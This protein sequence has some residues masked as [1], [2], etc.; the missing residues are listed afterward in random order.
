MIS[1]T[2]C[3]RDAMQG[4]K[5]Q[6]P[7]ELKAEYLNLLLKVGFGVIDF[8]SFVSAAAIPQMK[9]TAKVLAM[10]DLTKTKSRLLAIVANERGANDACSFQEITYLGFPFSISETFQQR[11]TNSGINESLKR[12]E[13]IQKLCSANNKELLVYISMAF[14]N[15]YGDEWSPELAVS[16]GKK[17]SSLGIKH[18]ALADTVGS[19]TPETITSL[20]ST[21]LPQL[22]GVTL[23]A[24]L[25]S[26]PEKSLEK[27]KAA[28]DSGCRNFDV[29]IH[30]FGGCPMA[31]E[32][33]TG[34]IA[35][36]FLTAFME[37]RKIKSGLDQTALK[38]AFE[39]SW[40][41]FN[42]YH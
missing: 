26:T 27:I 34:N 36:E 2:E 10:L 37:D 12:V 6:I 38:N 28:Y 20:F 13:E 9:D 22:Q 7:T 29:A 42:N 23:G 18:I 17:L 3:P 24:H 39:F 19:S 16:W 11:N 41:I 14:G 4:I 15:P 8:G 21:L 32:E 5:Q 30:G 1:I 40:K 35:T 25:H 31:K 33:L